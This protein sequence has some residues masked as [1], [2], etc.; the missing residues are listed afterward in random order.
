MCRGELKLR[1]CPTDMEIIIKDL[2][3]SFPR[4]VW[5]NK[6]SVTSYG[7]KAMRVVLGWNLQS[8]L[9]G[10]IK[11]CSFR[12]AGNALYSLCVVELKLK[13]YTA[14]MKIMIKELVWSVPYNFWQNKISSDSL[15]TYF[16]SCG[17]GFRLP[18]YATDIEIIM[19]QV[20]WVVSGNF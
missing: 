11:K 16:G 14:D 18:E 10:S 20:I 3:R 1:E 15:V 6:M 17:T 7:Q 19:K 8:M 12:K 13:E 5:Q 2:V 9:P 4:K